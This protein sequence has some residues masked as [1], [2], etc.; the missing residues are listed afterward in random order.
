[1]VSQ[2]TGVIIEIAHLCYHLFCLVMIF[3]GY[4]SFGMLDGGNV[5]I[6][7]YSVY[8]RHICSG[9]EGW[10]KAFLRDDFHGL[11]LW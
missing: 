4:L 3:C 10:G 6:S 7:M 1:M 9:V 5:G 11:P 8:M 2:V